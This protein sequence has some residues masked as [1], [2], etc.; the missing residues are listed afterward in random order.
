M[1]GKDEFEIRAVSFGSDMFKPTNN[2]EVD[3][4]MRRS[5][6]MCPLDVQRKLKMLAAARGVK[7]NDLMIEAMRD[8]L[9]KYGM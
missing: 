3:S 4:T 7:L 9:G 2:V 5:S 1:K 6:Y 8:L